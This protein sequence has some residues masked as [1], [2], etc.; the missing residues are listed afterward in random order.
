M[1]ALASHYMLRGW[2]IGCN[3]RT[4]RE[5]VNG[6]LEPARNMSGSAPP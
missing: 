6:I 5:G 2:L 1:Y 3:K 4:L